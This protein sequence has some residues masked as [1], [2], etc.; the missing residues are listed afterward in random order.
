MSSSIRARSAAACT[1]A[2]GSTEDDEDDEEED[3]T[4]TAADEF[5]L[6]KFQGAAGIGNDVTGGTPTHPASACLPKCQCQSANDGRAAAAAPESYPLGGRTLTYPDKDSPRTLT[7]CGAKC[8]VLFS[9]L[10][11]ALLLLTSPPQAPKAGGFSPP[12][13]SG[14]GGVPSSSGLFSRGFDIFKFIVYLYYC[15]LTL[16][17]CFLILL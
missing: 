6:F 13:E 14:I 1:E 10:P 2:T 7:R 5:V 11:P 9:L 16:Y 15:S 4:A 3:V 12:N 8:G 17:L